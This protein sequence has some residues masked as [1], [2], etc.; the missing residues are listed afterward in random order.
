MKLTPTTITVQIGAVWLVF[1]LLALGILGR[2]DLEDARRAE[3]Q[4]CQ[5][6]ET[7]VWP[8]YNTAIE[9]KQIP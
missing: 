8:H 6:V 2:G 9:C 4:Y 5:N 7:G 3:Q 1:F